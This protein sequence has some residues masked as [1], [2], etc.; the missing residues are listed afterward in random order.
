MWP[1][2]REPTCP[3]CS[4]ILRLVLQSYC[5]L[6]ASDFHR[7]LYVFACV[8]KSCWSEPHSWQVLRSQKICEDSKR[9]T[10]PKIKVP[11]DDWGT[12]MDDWGMGARGWDATETGLKSTAV[13]LAGGDNFTFAA[14]AHTQ[15]VIEASRTDT[16]HCQLEAHSSGDASGA[17]VKTELKQ[18]TLE[19][20]G[21]ELPNDFGVVKMDD[22]L[23]EKETIDS[24]WKLLSHPNQNES[25]SD[26]G[27]QPSEI[28][29]SYY[30]S[31]VEEED[32]E[33][34][35][36]S[37]HVQQLLWQYQQTERVDID[38]LMDDSKRD[39][40]KKRAG[41]GYEKDAVHHGDRTFYKFSKRLSH[42]PQQC[43]RYQWDG[44]TLFISTPS[45]PVTDQI[46]DRCRHCG[47]DKVFEL[48]LMP[49]LIH[50]LHYAGQEETA[51]EFGTV[52]IFTCRK[53]CWVDGDS[54]RAETVIVQADPD[55]HLFNRNGMDIYHN[56]N[57][58]NKQDE[59]AETVY[60]RR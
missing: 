8:N 43:I 40:G 12:E 29:Q 42:Y 6:E 21:D 27:R 24:M 44:Q 53:S 59:E 37:E 54:V 2:C 48:Q 15:N 28:L 23:P 17:F 47:A 50:Q 60:V 49:A 25:D 34:A 7:T 32:D 18:M 45:K 5:P 46:S 52:L 39:G 51:V 35:D 10:S 33:V 41:E 4:W 56:G 20:S 13:Q 31:V 22:C 14:A 16:E 11:V 55:S 19:D 30:I 3:R 38:A 9:V 57:K 58:D 1:G 26:V 36:A